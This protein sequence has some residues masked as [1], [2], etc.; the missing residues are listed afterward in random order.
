MNS[1]KHPPT[2]PQNDDLDIPV[3]ERKSVETL[4]PAD[5]RWPIGDPQQ[6]DFHFCGKHRSDGAPY[7]EV[8]MRRAFQA[9]RPRLAP[10]RPRALT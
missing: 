2:L 1:K 9:L 3:N 10:H 8:H 4:M 5:C 6:Q 7:C